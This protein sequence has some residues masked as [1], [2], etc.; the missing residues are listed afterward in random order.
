MVGD[1]GFRVV[2]RMKLTM[3]KGLKGWL[4]EKR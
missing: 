4:D 1:G 3:V 2:L